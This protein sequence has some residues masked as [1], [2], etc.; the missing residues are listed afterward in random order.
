MRII[1]FLMISHGVT[2]LQDAF[3]EAKANGF[4][5]TVIKKGELKLNVDETLEEVEEQITE[6]GSKIYHDKIMQERGVD[7]RTLMKGVVL[8][9]RAAKTR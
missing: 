1:H 9:D 7:I 3:R 5:V 6:K 2:F 4:N 8:A